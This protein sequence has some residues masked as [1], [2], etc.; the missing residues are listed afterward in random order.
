MRRV[1][2]PLTDDLFTHPP[3]ELAAAFERSFP[4]NKLSRNHVD[5][6]MKSSFLFPLPSLLPLLT[7]NMALALIQ[8][9]VSA[10]Y[11]LDEALVRELTLSEPASSHVGR[12]TFHG[13][14]LSIKQEDVVFMRGIQCLE[15]GITLP[16]MSTSI[17]RKEEEEKEADV[18]SATSLYPQVPK[19]HPYQQALAAWSGKVVPMGPDAKSLYAHYGVIFN[20]L[21]EETN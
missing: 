2:A 17:E 3:E 9:Q 1:D 13:E 21:Q 10:S 19:H 5:V 7:E 18:F 16:S 12:D 4:L 14:K 6:L 8:H 20:K 11:Q 15:R